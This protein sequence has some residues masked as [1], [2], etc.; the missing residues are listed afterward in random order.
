MHCE[1]NVTCSEKISCIIQEIDN[2]FNY[3]ITQKNYA[4]G[5]IKLYIL[6]LTGLFGY[7]AF[8]QTKILYRTTKQPIFFDGSHFTYSIFGIFFSL[9]VFVI[10]WALQSYLSHVISG[11]SI[12]YKHISNM[13]K[14][15]SCIFPNDDFKE[16][17]IMPC[18]HTKVSVFYS[19]HLP[20][21]FNIINLMTLLMIYY[22]LQVSVFWFFSYLIS[23]VII[24]IFGIY[25]PTS[26]QNFYKEIMC[27]LR[28]TPYKQEKFVREAINDGLVKSPIGLRWLQY[29][30]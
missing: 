27:A 12:S 14:L 26:C 24:F 30:V 18:Y 29:I 25:Y 15:K 20:I 3:I 11:I 7:A 9:L 1:T 28:V 4:I 23:S 6:T 17:S 19:Q 21:I 22:F 13:R 16:H 5:I 8:L 2:S 10:G